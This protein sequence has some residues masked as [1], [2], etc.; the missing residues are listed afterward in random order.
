MNISIVFI[1]ALAEGA[2]MRMNSLSGK[3]SNTG[4]QREDFPDLTFSGLVDSIRT[5]F[6]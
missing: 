6:G 1:V 4:E 2:V 3:E 5:F